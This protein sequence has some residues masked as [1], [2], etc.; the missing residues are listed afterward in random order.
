MMRTVL[1][2]AVLAAACASGTDT[3]EKAESEAEGPTFY[4][5]VLP[6]V[7]ENCQGC[8]NTDSPLG[9]AFPLES[10]AH[11]A[12]LAEFLLAKMQP[13]GD[14]DDAPFFMPPIYAR[15]TD[16]CSPS[17]PWQG[18]YAASDEEIEL[19]ESWIDAGKLEGNPEEPATFERPAVPSLEDPTATMTFKGSYEVPAPTD[20]TYD[21]F[22][23]FALE[24]EQGEVDFSDDTWLNGF[25]FEPGNDKV[26]H[27]VLVYTVSGLNAHLAGGI[28]EDSS[29]NSWDCNGGISR[30]DGS[31]TIGAFNLIYGW[32]PGSLPISLQDGMAMQVPANTGLVAQI[33]YN[34]LSSSASTAD[35]TDQSKLQIRAT[36]EPSR[37][38]YIHLFGVAGVGETD[39]V[40]EPPFL[41]PEGA[42]GHV[43]SYTEV[44]PS[45]LDGIDMRVW[46]FVPHMHLAG[47]QIKLERIRTDGSLDCFMHVPRWDYNWQQFY[48]YDGS[49]DELPRLLGNESM[50]VTCTLDNSDDNPFL[51]EY[52]GG[53]V[54]G[55]V[56]LGEGTEEEMCLVAIGL[57]CEGLCPD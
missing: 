3:P 32:A 50:K 34:T 16:E 33:H 18:A 36:G 31:Y 43:E 17:L 20:G 38:A 37:E 48:V 8:H 9:Q 22:R 11:V 24:D 30:A 25:G 26:V 39:D 46:G 56:K 55:G 51:K 15:N 28:A 44:L 5:D 52:L 10:Y 21:T 19:F 54:A 49:F 57:A 2:C 35:R 1:G 29:N 53:A 6:V 23:C 41:V 40:D 47:T 42:S 12:P 14:P 45:N 4:Q 27:H 7:G 13:E